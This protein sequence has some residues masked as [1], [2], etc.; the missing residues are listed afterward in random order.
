MSVGIFRLVLM[1]REAFNTFFDLKDITKLL[2]Q[3]KYRFLSLEVLVDNVGRDS[4][5]LHRLLGEL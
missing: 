3:D 1:L 2:L 4:V 5:P